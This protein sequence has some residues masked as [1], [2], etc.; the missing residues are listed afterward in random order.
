MLAAIVGA[1]LSVGQPPETIALPKARWSLKADAAYCRLERQA[2]GPNAILMIDTIPGSDSYNVAIAGGEM[3]RPHQ[4]ASGSLIFEPMH[5]SLNGLVTVARG[6]DGVPF[7]RI[8]DIPPAALDDLAD[9]ATIS[10]AAK[11]KTSPVVSIP[12]AAK[13]IAAFRQ[14]SAGQLMDWGAD[15]AQFASGGRPPVASKHRDDWLSKRELLAVMAQSE[16]SDID[17]VFRVGVSTTGTIDD[18]RAVKADT[19]DGVTKVACAAVMNKVLFA[20]AT[21]PH[22]HPVRGVATFRV[23]LASRPS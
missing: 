23:V 9:A 8:I 10:L 5:E 12:N 2:A 3:D 19:A 14:C 4:L 15:P 6:P 16:R 20:P 11:T 1:L 18:C 17:A 21:D 13:A 7:W 22:G